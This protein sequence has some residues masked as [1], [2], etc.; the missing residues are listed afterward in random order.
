[1]WNPKEI[2]KSWARSKSLSDLVALEAT[3]LRGL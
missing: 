1:M 3:A 2:S